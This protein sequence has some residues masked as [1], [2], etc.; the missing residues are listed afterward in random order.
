MHNKL[1]LGEEEA[2]RLRLVRCIHHLLLLLLAQLG[3][4]VHILPLIRALRHTEWE[5][6]LKL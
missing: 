1:A 5:A 4:L 6:E 3:Q 2:I